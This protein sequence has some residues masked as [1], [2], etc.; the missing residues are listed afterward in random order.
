MLPRKLDMYLVET[1]VWAPLHITASSSY[2]DDLQEKKD[3]KSSINPYR[4]LHLW[5]QT[6]E[7]KMG[8]KTLATKIKKKTHKPL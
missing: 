8:S 6:R 3:N 1:Q 7:I 2:I 5:I 4:T